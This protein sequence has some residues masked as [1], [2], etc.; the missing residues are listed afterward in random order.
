M[1][2]PDFKGLLKVDRVVQ[3]L[4]II[5]PILL[6]LLLFS[7]TWNLGKVLILLPAD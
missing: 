2:T 4:S 6:P 5:P 3:H 1:S 7:I